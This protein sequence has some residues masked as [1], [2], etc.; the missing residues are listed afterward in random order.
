MQHG[1]YDLC[2]CLVTNNHFIV[3][4]FTRL[5]PRCVALQH[6]PPEMLQQGHAS[7][8]AD[9]YAFGIMSECLDMG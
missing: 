5:H 7:P 3:V 6:C 1:H 8:Q 2:F 4:G 9:V